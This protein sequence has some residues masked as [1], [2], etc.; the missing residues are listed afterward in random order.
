MPPSYPTTLVVTRHGGG[1]YVAAIDAVESIELIWP[2]VIELA[3]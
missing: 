3:D 1:V 2:E